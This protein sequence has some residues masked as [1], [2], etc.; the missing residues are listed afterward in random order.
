MIYKLDFPSTSQI[1]PVFHVSQLKPFVGSEV[2]P[3]GATL[4]NYDEDSQNLI[5]P[6]AIVDRRTISVDNQLKPQVL[7]QWDG[8]PVEDSSW[9]DVNVLQEI[10]PH[11]NLEDQ[12]CFDDGGNVTN[13]AAVPENTEERRESGSVT[14]NRSRRRPNWMDD[15][16]T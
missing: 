6:L 7:V 5:C 10:F 15:Y 1:H 11:L 9:E 2:L 16:E 13:V 8:L 3:G 14:N 12:V 4:P